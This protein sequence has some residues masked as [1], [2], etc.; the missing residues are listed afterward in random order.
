MNYVKYI[1]LILLS[2]IY[3]IN[4]QSSIYID[5]KVS[6]ICTALP[7]TKIEVIHLSPDLPECEFLEEKKEFYSHGG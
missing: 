6:N 2:I 7:R 4:Y 3:L 1:P 5:W